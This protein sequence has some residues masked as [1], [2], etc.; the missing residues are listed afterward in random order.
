MEAVTWEVV[1]EADKMLYGSC[2]M[3]VLGVWM[4]LHGT[5]YM[6]VIRCYTEDV[7]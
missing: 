5:C 2:Y 4:M 7:I 3:Q 6:K 1:Y